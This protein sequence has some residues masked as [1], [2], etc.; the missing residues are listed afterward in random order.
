MNLREWQRREHR[1]RRVRTQLKADG[2]WSENNLLLF[3]RQNGEFP[4]GSLV[5][6]ESGNL[7]GTTWLGGAYSMGVVFE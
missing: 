1:G 2:N 5:A 6:D 4:E 3:T 7:Y